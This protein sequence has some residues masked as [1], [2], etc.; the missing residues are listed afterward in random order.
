MPLETSW[1]SSL[2][3]GPNGAGDL[4]SKQLANPTPEK[5]LLHPKHQDSLLDRDYKQFALN[6]QVKSV[7][8]HHLNSTQGFKTAV[9]GKSN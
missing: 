2:G 9:T 7:A 4:L 8:I 6:Q 3:T 5:S 1:F